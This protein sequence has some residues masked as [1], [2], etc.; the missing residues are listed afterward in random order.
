MPPTA[1]DLLIAPGQQGAV[2]EAP[3]RGETAVDTTLVSEVVALQRAT[4]WPRP[5]AD[6]RHR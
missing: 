6:P 2:T 4:R 5:L 1:T 3:L